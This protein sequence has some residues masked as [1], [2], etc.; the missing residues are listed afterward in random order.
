MNRLCLAVAALVLCASA[1]KA[2]SAASPD[3]K[4]TASAKGTTIQVTDNQ[5]QKLVM[6]IQAHKSD[7]TGL[8]YSPDGKHLASVDKD[9]ALK[10]FGTGKKARFD[11][12]RV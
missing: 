3:G 5:T 6:S 1:A 9:G 12:K 2:Q 4:L 11:W 7:L 10:L 8:A